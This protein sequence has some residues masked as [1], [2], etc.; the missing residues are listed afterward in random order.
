MDWNSARNLST[1]RVPS[2]GVPE[3]KEARVE[4]GGSLRG[5]GKRLAVTSDA[6]LSVFIS[7]LTGCVTLY[8]SPAHSVPWMSHLYNGE[9]KTSARK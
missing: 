4:C 2:A 8:Q 5:V 7:P 6:W 1:H 3:V 9:N